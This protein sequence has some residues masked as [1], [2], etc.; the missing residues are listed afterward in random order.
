M[1]TERTNDFD[2]AQGAGQAT[3]DPMRSSADWSTA[4]ADLDDTAAISTGGQEPTETVDDLERVSG[5]SPRAA[6]T[7]RPA[8]RPAATGRQQAAA[9]VPATTAPA[10]TPHW[11]PDMARPDRAA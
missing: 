11:A 6:P 4:T 9:R 1:T 8:T 7:A 10:A 5:T 2:E 3:D